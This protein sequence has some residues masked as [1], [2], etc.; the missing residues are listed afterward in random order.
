MT[1]AA[2]VP[3]PPPRPVVT[4]TRSAPASTSR[5]P[6]RIFEGRGPADVR[7]GAGAESLRQLLADLDLDGR[8]ILVERLRIGVRDDEFDVAESGFH[9][10][11][12]A[13]PPPPPTPITLILAPSF[14]GSSSSRIRIGS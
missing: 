5:I 11:F 3:V 8:R 4:K 7:I 10:R 6:L 12:T 13:F 1:G 14:G 2:P 9:H